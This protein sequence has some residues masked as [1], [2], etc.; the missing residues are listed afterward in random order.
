MVS[1]KLGPAV[2]VKAIVPIE[3]GA[4]RERNVADVGESECRL[5]SSSI[6]DRLGRPIQRRVPVRG[7][8]V[9]LPSCAP[10]K[11]RASREEQKEQRKEK[12]EGPPVETKKQ[13]NTLAE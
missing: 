11:G 12:E 6:W 3:P 5:V 7:A 8:G 4:N 9:N 13:K 10:S 2:I 1:V